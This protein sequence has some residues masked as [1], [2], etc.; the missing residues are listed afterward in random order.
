[1][2]EKWE[3]QEILKQIAVSPKAQAPP[4]QKGLMRHAASWGKLP[5]P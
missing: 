5:K 2:L 1:M 4:E 3:F